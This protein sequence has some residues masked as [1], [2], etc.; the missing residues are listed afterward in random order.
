MLAL[1]IQDHKTA[2]RM[3]NHIARKCTHTRAYVHVHVHEHVAIETVRVVG[4]KALW[5]QE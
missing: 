4:P 5:L 3:Y 2:G 1:R